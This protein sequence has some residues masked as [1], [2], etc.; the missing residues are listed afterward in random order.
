[1]FILKYI[2]QEDTT[3]EEV[4]NVA[5]ITEP[6]INSENSNLETEIN[7]SLTENITETNI[8]SPDGSYNDETTN[9][10]NNEEST[11]PT[12]PEL[13]LPEEDIK[14]N[15]TVDTTPSYKVDFR[16]ISKNIVEI[17]GEFPI[18]TDGFTLSR[19][20]HTDN[21]DYSSF[22]TIY[23]KIDGGCQFSNDESVYV[24]PEVIEPTQEELLLIFEANKRN[25]IEQSKY[26]LATYLDTHPLMSDCHGGVMDTYSITSEKQALLSS[27]YLTY[28][29]AKQSGVENPVLT[30]NASGKECEVWTEEEYV[31]LVLQIGAYV[32]PLVSMQQSYEVQINACTTQEELD[33]I[34]IN[35]NIYEN[36]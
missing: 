32:K 2:T 26:L 7:E 23:K 11:H 13:P 35:Y 15:E 5:N 28:T 16:K 3:T 22:T 4:V 17:T 27:N 34:I 8:G 25:K 9:P 18:K 30:W 6:M 20:N 24:E 29:I 31:T 12:E 10:D 19:E 1:M 33:N 36:S 21:W 14:Q